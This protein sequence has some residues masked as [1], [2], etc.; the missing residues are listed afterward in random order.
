MGAS[1]VGLV[2]LPADCLRELRDLHGGQKHAVDDCNQPH[3][4]IR[5][6]KQKQKHNS[7]WRDRTADLLR[8]V[9]VKET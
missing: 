4:Y 6:H 1:E 3:T 7:Q 5:V 9:N 8:T 2:S